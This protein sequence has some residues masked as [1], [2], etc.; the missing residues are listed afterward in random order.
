MQVVSDLLALVSEDRIGRVG[1]GATGQV[2]EKPVQLC[3]GM[4]RPRKSAAAETCGLET[5]ILAIFLH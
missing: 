3:P 5:E 4:G 1:N 2:G